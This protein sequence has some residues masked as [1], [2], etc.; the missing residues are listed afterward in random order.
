MADAPSEPRGLDPRDPDTLAQRAMEALQNE[1]PR[2]ARALLLEAAQLSPERPDLLNALGVVHLHLGEPELGK[3]FI[4]QAVEMALAHRAIPERRIAAE[5]MVEGFLLG[6][7][8]ACED[9]DQ[10]REAQ[11]AYAQL[12]ALSP[13]QPRARNGLAHLLLGWGRT[14]EGVVMLATY[15]EE[16]ADEPQFQAAAEAVRDAIEKVRDTKLHPRMFLEAHRESY[17]EF[18]NHH[19]EEQGA[20]G[21]IAEAARMR[22]DAAGGIVPVIPEGARPYASVRVDLVNPETGEIG[23]VGDQPMVV[24]LAGFEPLARV[25]VLFDWLDVD[26]PLSVS[27]QCPWDQLPVQVL[28]RDVGATDALD[29]AMGAWFTKGWS[30]AWGTPEEGRLHY[31]SDPELRRGGRGV[32]YHVDCGRARFDAIPA[33][34]EVL[35]AVSRTWPIERVIL[36]RGYLP[37]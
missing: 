24:A 5:T 35:A 1:D 31:I 4:V 17:V 6:L 14:V 18:F 27:T 13:G 28:F 37:E 32:V 19:A 23:Q 34:I 10:P 12:L 16:D 22:R 26:F 25:A 8:A 33:L 30:G 36:G 15:L 2:A 3:P 9:L 7:A 21:W 11:A 20:K 29:A